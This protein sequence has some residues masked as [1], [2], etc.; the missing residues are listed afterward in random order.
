M[1]NAGPTVVVFAAQWCLPSQKLVRSFEQIGL[2]PGVSV[3]VI[4]VDTYPEAPA[5]FGV[6][7]IPTTMVFKDGAVEATRLGDLPFDRLR[8]WVGDLI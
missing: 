2:I 7:G 6:R 8:E 3:Q 4:D 1:Q 5:R